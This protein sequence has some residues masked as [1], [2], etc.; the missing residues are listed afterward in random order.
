MKSRG[1]SLV[2]IAISLGIFSFCLLAVLGLFTAGLKTE[3]SSQEEDGASSTLASLSLSLENSVSS[4]SDTYTTVAPL[5]GWAWKPASPTGSQTQGQIG[6]Y[7]YWIRVRQVNV[8]GDSKLINA[9]LELAWPP[10]SVQWDGEGHATRARGSASSSLFFF[11][12]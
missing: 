12:K 7:A 2:E 3:R 8:T 1:F 10:D 9:R 4:S 6:E 11:A 5:A